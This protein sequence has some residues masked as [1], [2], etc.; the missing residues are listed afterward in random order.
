LRWPTKAPA[1]CLFRTSPS[2]RSRSSPAGLETPTA[3]SCNGCTYEPPLAASADPHTLNMFRGF[4]PIAEGAALSPERVAA[5]VTPWRAIGLQLCEGEKDKWQLMEQWLAHIIQF[6]EQAG[7]VAQHLRDLE[8]VAPRSTLSAHPGRVSELVP[9]LRA[10]KS[11]LLLLHLLLAPL[12]AAL[13]LCHSSLCRQSS[14]LFCVQPC[15]ALR[16]CGES[17]RPEHRSCHTTGAP[18]ETYA[19][20]HAALGGTN[21]YPAACSS[22]PHRAAN[23]SER[24]RAHAPPRVLAAWPAARLVARACCATRVATRPPRGRLLAGTSHAPGNPPQAVPP[25]QTCRRRASDSWKRDIRVMIIVQTEGQLQ[26]ACSYS[27][28]R[29][30]RVPCWQHETHE[31]KRAKR[32]I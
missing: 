25:Q 26:R 1:R 2:G 28:K 32:R 9:K 12:A 6:P 5:L 27:A 4:G 17:A 8:V 15:C 19:A 3:A 16:K 30:R 24:R 11:D 23:A 13:H 18:T 31:G 22:Q 10:L 14:G 7:H 21:V 29:S 20:R